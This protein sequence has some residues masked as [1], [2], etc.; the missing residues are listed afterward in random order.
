MHCKSDG[1]DDIKRNNSFSLYISV[2]LFVVSHLK[3]V[4]TGCSEFVL[5]EVLW[6]YLHAILDIFSRP[7]CGTG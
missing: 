1:W 6:M 4:L 2:S 3:A 5:R 7:M